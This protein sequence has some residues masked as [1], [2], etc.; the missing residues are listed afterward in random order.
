MVSPNK[1]KKASL[2]LRKKLREAHKGLPSPKKG[3]PGHKHSEETKEKI[4]QTNKRIGKKPP[5]NGG[6]RH[7]NWQGGKTP[8]NKRIRVSKEY[9]LW[10]SAVFER[11]NYACIWCGA[12]SQKG[13]TVFL[14]ADH[15]KPFAYYPELRLAIDNGRT[16][17][18]S[19]HRTTDTYAGRAKSK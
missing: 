12:K 17:C 7:W 14:H 1:G 6:D 11:D 5:Y 9:K 8:L 4:R 18:V 13:Q 19:C 3:K 16:L 15:I 2:E 10:R